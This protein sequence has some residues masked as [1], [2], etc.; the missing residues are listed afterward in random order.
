[1]ER[2][3]RRFPQVLEL[4]LEPTATAQTDAGYTAR[5]AG[6]GDLDVCCGFLEHVRQ[7]PAST[8]ETLLL[9]QALEASLL[10]QME[11]VASAS[12][13]EGVAALE[14]T[15]LAELAERGA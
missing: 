3:R 14:L 13:A 4:R 11:G 12:S 1:M 7:R 10:N 5:V 2:L 6:L 15:E 8:E 9:Q